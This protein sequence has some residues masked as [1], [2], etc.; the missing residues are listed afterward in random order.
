MKP[1]RLI[2]SALLGIGLAL[3]LACVQSSDTS[4]TAL[5]AFDTTNLNVLMW[6]DME[7][8]YDTGSTT[9]LTT[10]PSPTKTISSDYFSE[11]SN[12]AWGGMCIDRSHNRL[13]MVNEDGLICRVDSIRSRTDG[14]S[15]GSSYARTFQLGSDDDDRL[16]SGTFGQIAVDPS[17]GY[18]YV[19]EWSSSDSRIWV[20]TSPTSYAQDD[21]VAYSSVTTM[22][23]SGDKYGYGVAVGGSS[24]VFAYFNTGSTVTDS[25]S[26]TH[27]GAR[28]RLGTASGG[29]SSV[30]VGTSNTKLAQYGLLGADSLNGIVY[31]CRLATSNPVIAF[32][33]SKFS[34]GYDVAPSFT[35]P[36][37]STTPLYVRVLAHP[38]NKDWLVGSG[39]TSS[40]GADY[41]SLWMS[42]STDTSTEP[43]IFSYGSTLRGITLDGNAAD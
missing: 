28:L 10:L 16:S 11:F 4:N 38:G 17:T 42:P 19:T 39:S 18:L 24:R 21:T 14:S 34:T 12:M 8:L 27:T 5:Y 41:L 6:S 40:G 32:K 15:L 25:N 3:N 43:V 26:T 20:L 23:V 35:L 36:N 9:S 7:T 13:W 37:S 22:D 30:I 2:L 29:F 33:N 31:S 1:L